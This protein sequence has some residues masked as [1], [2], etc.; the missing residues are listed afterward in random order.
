MNVTE[1]KAKKSFNG[2]VHPDENKQLTE[3]KLES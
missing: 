1:L 2:G 3:N